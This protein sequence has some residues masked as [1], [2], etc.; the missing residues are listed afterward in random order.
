MSLLKY[1][2]KPLARSVKS[3]LRSPV[4]RYII[5]SS[6]EIRK[7]PN[8]IDLVDNK[9]ERQRWADLTAEEFG[10]KPTDMEYIF[11]KLTYY[12][13]LQGNC[14][15]TMVLEGARM[16]C[17]NDVPDDNQLLK[18]VKHYAAILEAHPKQKMELKDS[19]TLMLIDPPL[20]YP[21]DYKL[22]HLLQSPIESPDAALKVRNLGDRPGSF[23]A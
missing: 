9:E 14:Q 7:N 21:L 8:W 19:A 4:E 12:K 6:A 15:G 18:E 1:E 17:V 5:K 11:E 20:L 16:V 10:T 3:P 23:E 22:S 2:P 13:S